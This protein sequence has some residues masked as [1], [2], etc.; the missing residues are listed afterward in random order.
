MPAPRP[1][2]R[3]SPADAQKL[4]EASADLGFNRPSSE[5]MPAGSHEA[6][7]KP[8]PPA[9]PKP[10]TARA[11]PGRIGTREEVKARQM[12][13]RAAKI[14][15]RTPRPAPELSDIGQTLRLDVPDEVWTALKIA[16]VHRRVTVKY[17]VLEAL[18]KAGYPV[19]LR[20]IPE[21]GRRMR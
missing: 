14:A 20:L 17:L 2:T 4:I 15:Q 21:D 8:V 12:A 19:D 3:L 16:C 7:E 6:H 1:T 9:A 11:T 5:A 18:K 13:R 10:A